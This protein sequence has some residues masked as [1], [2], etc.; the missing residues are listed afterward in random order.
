MQN[1]VQI[2]CTKKISNSFIRPAEENNIWIDELNFIETEE[3]VSEAIKNRIL[4]LSKQNITVIFTSSKAVNVV[5]K[6]VSPETK[7]KI[8]CI[9]PATKKKVEKIF[10]NALI[11]G[12]AK[13]AEELTQKI[14]K[15]ISVKQIVFFCGN[16]RRDSLPEQLKRKGINVEE[17]IV[18]KTIEKPQ[19]VVKN[20][21]GILFFS[22]SA[23]RSFFSN[24]KIEP[25]TVLFTIG[26]TTAQEVKNFSNNKTVI[27]EIPENE[28]LIAEVVNY[29]STKN[30]LN[31]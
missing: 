7:W 17:L 28:K 12:S 13:N 2:L 25:E 15:D 27:S 23:V 14:I 19:H 5:G 21:N 16:Q 26:K 9:E 20:Y 1:K 18:Y 8:F 30:C 22:P 31:E 6:I 24:N 29:F 11:S 4:T 10:A 3:S